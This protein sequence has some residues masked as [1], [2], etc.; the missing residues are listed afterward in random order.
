MFSLSRNILHSQLIRG[1]RRSSSLRHSSWRGPLPTT[2]T[3]RTIT[4][5]SPLSPVSSKSTYLESLQQIR[6]KSK[7]T[8]SSQSPLSGLWKPTH[9]QQLFYGSDCVSKHLLECLPNE[10]SKAFIITG[11]SLYEKTPVIKNIEKTLGSA[12]GGTF[13]KIGQ[14]A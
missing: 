1:C 3:T 5:S 12:H 7:M 13:S 8:E 9:L 10:K 14:H 2:S 11:R 4:T 6:H